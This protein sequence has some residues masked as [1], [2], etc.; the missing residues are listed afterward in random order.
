MYSRKESQVKAFL[1]NPVNQSI[2]SIDIGGH[3]DI[4]KLVGY[5]TI[6][7][8]AVGNQGNSLYFEE[9][10]LLRSMRKMEIEI[11]SNKCKTPAVETID[12]IGECRR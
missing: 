2:E 1:I 11:R 6:E 12:R 5:D 4:A 7:S 9:E 8:E 3:K 10:L